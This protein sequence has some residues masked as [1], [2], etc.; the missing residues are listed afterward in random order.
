MFICPQRLLH[1]M[2]ALKERQNSFKY[3]PSV[4]HC[5]SVSS[6]HACHAAGP[7]SIPGWDKFPG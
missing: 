4:H 7:G 2:C 6:M 1:G 3:T 5:G